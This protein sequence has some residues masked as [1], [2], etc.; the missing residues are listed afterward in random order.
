M[1]VP[2]ALAGLVD[3]DGPA[4]RA[5][6]TQELAKPEYHPTPN[7][8]SKVIAWL[9]DRLDALLGAAAGGSPVPSVL[10]VAVGG[11]LLV[12]LVVAVSRVRRTRRVS[13]GS[14]P[15]LADLSLTRDQLRDRA[16]QAYA[17]GDFSAAVVWWYRA[18]ARQAADRTVL[19][20][21]ENLTA[22][23]IA[24]RLAVAFPG[25]AAATQHGATLFDAVRYGHRT[26]R[27][28][29]A[30]QLRELDRAV[31][32]ARPQLP[33]DPLAQREIVPVGGPR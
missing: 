24:D 7:L 8:L 1:S 3:P 5:W 31:E 22:H 15:V 27:R 9:F 30:D 25:L 23:E 29:E 26:A 6:F 14:A 17:G 2:V 18:L 32:R 11:A 33:A 19:A 16:Q 10:G 21:V 28:E 12:A 4:A 20:A 13:G